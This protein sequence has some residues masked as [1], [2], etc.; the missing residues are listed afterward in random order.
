VTA[1]TLL[2]E[3]VVVLAEGDLDHVAHVG[4][5]AALA[6][7]LLLV[8]GL[9]AALRIL[10]PLNVGVVLASTLNLT[11]LGLD[12]RVEGTKLLVQ[13]ADVAAVVV[14]HALFVG[15]QLRYGVAACLTRH[16]QNSLAAAELGGS[17]VVCLV[18]A[19]NKLPKE[20]LHGEPLRCECARRLGGS[21]TER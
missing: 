9:Q 6:V 18:P 12:L 7:D 8:D 17:F 1:Q 3:T 19:S 20:F 10:D 16:V 5:C 13:L 14:E 21:G 4:L 11:L 15:V 2:G